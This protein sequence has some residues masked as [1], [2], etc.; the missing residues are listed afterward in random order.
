MTPT[1]ELR[2]I[3]DEMG[4]EYEEPHAGFTIVRT[5]NAV[6]K[7]YETPD[8]PERGVFAV[9]TTD[10]LTP[11]QAIAAAIGTN[12]NRLADLSKQL[13]KVYGLHAFAEL[14]GFD[15]KDDS[16]WT[17]HDVACAM[18]DAIDAATVGI[19]LSCASCPEMDNPDSYIIH[20]QR[21]LDYADKAATV[22]AG[23]CKN[24]AEL[25]EEGMAGYFF[26]CS[27]CGLAVH[28]DNCINETNYPEKRQD[29]SIDLQTF[30][31]NGRY[32]FERC[33]RCGRRIEV[34]E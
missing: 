16:D 5:K 10:W 27:E 13:R 8:E 6:C 22:G 31:S 7:F 28:V 34:G 4:V 17:W 19:K 11:A 3:L 9:V 32:E 18:A 20:L 33:P 23:T 2:K 24:I 25:N 12:V 21:A 15:W 29:G 26:V 1:E 30:N 14:F